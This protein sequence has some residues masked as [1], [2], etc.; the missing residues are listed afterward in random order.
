MKYEVLN[1]NN[2][3]KSNRAYTW[4]TLN[5]VNGGLDNLCSLLLILMRKIF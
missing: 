2:V 4:S 1:D 5:T 3:V